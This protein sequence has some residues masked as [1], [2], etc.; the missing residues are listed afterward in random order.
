[1]NRPRHSQMAGLAGA[2][3]TLRD[4]PPIASAMR[5]KS[6][7]TNYRPA[8]A[9]AR[10]TTLVAPPSRPVETGSERRWKKAFAAMG[11]PL[12]TD[13]VALIGQYGSGIWADS[14]CVW[15]PFTRGRTNL[16]EDSR[17]LCDFHREH[18]P[19]EDERYFPE[20][21]GYLPWG[22]DDNGNYYFWVTV[23]RPDAWTVAANG[24]DGEFYAYRLNLVSFLV[25]L[26]RRR[27]KTPFLPT[28]IDDEP[29]W[30]R[31]TFH[32]IR[33]PRKKLSENVGPPPPPR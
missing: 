18:R 25:A 21:G 24:E 8:V 3:R 13:Y 23:G 22:H 33:R 26:F 31:P 4:L 5:K 7:P 27:I 9:L 1:M 15:N 6:I 20:P 30:P 32:K 12:P 29:W 19:C 10:L 16:I 14:L 11:L 2:R 28:A 17:W